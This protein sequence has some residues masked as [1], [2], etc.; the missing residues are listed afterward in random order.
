MCS[1]VRAVL[2]AIGLGFCGMSI[3]A[4]VPEDER[5]ELAHRLIGHVLGELD[6]EPMRCP[7]WVQGTPMSLAYC[8]K[9]KQL[10]G[11]D[12]ADA[13][14]RIDRLVEPHA[15]PAEA[16]KVDGKIH[17]RQYR[18]GDLTL[19]LRLNS[20]EGVAGF[21][22][23]RQNYGCIA[24]KSVPA[25]NAPGLTT[26]VLVESSRVAP[27]YPSGA[28]DQRRDGAVALEAVIDERG[29]VAELCVIELIGGDMEFAEA[30]ISAVR[31]WKY[32]PAE[33]DGQ[34]VASRFIVVVSF[35]VH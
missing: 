22:Y 2:L 35:K 28:F 25:G 17:Q 31:Q 6:C 7:S 12:H 11:A 23:A 19:T 10:E 14:R 4:Q 13:R 29:S 20:K 18:L 33:L 32:E 16:W 15:E 26:P 24:D 9:S 27:L 3:A 21:L 8:G 5:H 30:A 1:A 34:P